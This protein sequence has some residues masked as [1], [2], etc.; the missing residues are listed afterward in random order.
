[1]IP[2]RLITLVLK[3]ALLPYWIFRTVS[4]YAIA[5]LNVNPTLAFVVS[6]AA[7][8]GT[9]IVSLKIPI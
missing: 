5:T 1:M 7:A 2:L 8:F 6:A 3:T 4:D 9:L